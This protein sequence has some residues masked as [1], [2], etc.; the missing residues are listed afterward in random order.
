MKLACFTSVFGFTYGEGDPIL[1]NPERVG[2]VRRLAM[3]NNT[4]FVADMSV[5]M[6]TDRHGERPPKITLDKPCTVLLVD[7]REIFVK[8]SIEIVL[9]RLGITDVAPYNPNWAEIVFNPETKS[10]IKLD[11]WDPK[12]ADPNP[13]S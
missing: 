9:E 3:C 12:S 2:G 5:L 6:C 11:R 10:D 7:G 8:E 4:V 13:L 1:I